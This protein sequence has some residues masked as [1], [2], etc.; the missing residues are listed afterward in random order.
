MKGNSR[1]PSVPPPPPAPQ[2]PTSKAT[3]KYTNKDG[4]KFIT[5]PKGS[6]PADSA[7]PSPTITTAANATPGPQLAST[8]HTQGHGQGQVERQVQPVNKK[9]AKRR[10]KAAAKAAATQGIANPAPSNGFPSPSPSNAQQSTEADHD[11]S[12]DEHPEEFNDRRDSRTSNTHENGFAEG[13]PTSSKKSKKKKKKSNATAEL[14][15]S[16]RHD[17]YLSAP[18]LSQQQRSGISKEKIW[19]TSS[20]E[21]RE[22]IKEFWLGLSET[23]RKELVKVEKDAVLKKMKEQQKHTCS[24]TVCGRKRTAIEEE[25]EGLYDAYYEELEQYANHPN[26]GEAPPMLGRR[27]S[28]GSMTG[29]RPRGLPTSYSSHHQPSHGQIVDHGAE[30]DDEEEEVEEE[31]SE[32]EQE[33]DDY[34]DD[35]PSEELHRSDYPADFFN[36]GNSLTVQGGILTVADDLLKND[37]KKFIEMMEQLAERRMAREEDAREQF[38]SPF[39]HS[40]NGDRNAHYHPPADD[41]VDDDD[42]DEDYD[43]DDDE[44]EY[45]SGD[46]EETMTEEQRMEEGRRMFQIF[47]A[48]MFEQRVLT[49]YREKVARERQNM[50][51]EE[52]ADEKRRTEERQVKKQKEAQKKKERQARKRELQAEEKARREEE[53]IAE[54]KAKKAEEDRQKEQRRQREEEKRKHKEAQKKAEEEERKRKEAE[55]QRR[56]HEREENERKAR[57]AR[58]R[59][60][61]AREEA[62]L[63]EKEAREQKEREAREQKE[64]Q[65][66]EKREREAKAKAEMEAARAAKEKSKQEDRA[67]QKA[68]ALATTAPVPITLPKRPAQLAQTSVPVPALPQQPAVYA[69]P[70]I[71]VATPAFPKAPAPAQSRQTHQQES[72]TTSSGSTSQPGSAASQNPSPHTLT[73]VHTSPGPMKPPSK[74]GIVVGGTQSSGVH[75]PSPAPS[76]TVN[77]GPKSLQSQPSPFGGPSMNMPFQPTPQPPPGFSN[78]MQPQYPPFYNPANSYNRVAPGMMAAPPGFSTPLSGRAMPMHPPGFPGPLDSPVS[79]FAGLPSGLSSLI[80]KDSVPSHARQG[81]GSFETGPVGSS[82]QPISR[83]TPIGRPASVVH[84]QR[85]SPESSTNGTDKAEQEVHLGSSALLEPDDTQQDFPTRPHFGLLGTSAPGVRPAPGF[86]GGP[87]GMEPGFPLPHQNN[88]WNPAPP[89]QHNPFVPPPPGFPSSS[90]HG[91]WSQ[92]APPGIMGR[93]P[94]IVER[95]A[96]RSVTLRKAL[97]AVCEDLGAGGSSSYDGFIPLGEIMVHMKQFTVNEKEVLDICDTEGNPSNG[98]GSFVVRDPSSPTGTPLIRYVPDDDASRAPYRPIKHPGD[99]G[100]PIVG[101]GSFNV[102]S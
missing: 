94:S 54:E 50:L 24:C 3:A 102:R 65:E 11:D 8:S 71:P 29:M 70:V 18:H 101:S 91:P 93:N 68:A 82:S 12:H 59:E 51:L 14:L 89:L 53:K 32:D 79:S 41:E 13:A 47:A 100:S 28:F 2:S 46:E 27:P 23:E 5:V 36:F 74:P 62:R 72:V 98:G 7:Q 56:N 86:G 22:R 31:Y 57:E 20:Q 49:A 55:R 35:E 95:S 77:A 73:P 78:H 40:T 67:A 81:S 75:L 19:N 10:Q 45:D 61:K 97:C 52:L 99:I 15:N 80:G 26:Q 85:R 76:T 25:L 9:K 96:P 43:D 90:H 44:E 83:P 92:A 33:E 21:E 30:E 42:Y 84:G 64:Q 37:G 1:H 39:P 88:P 66:R 63:K 16:P 60:K 58:E 69:S 34:S 4:S 6:T 17:A 48:R 87:F 38:N